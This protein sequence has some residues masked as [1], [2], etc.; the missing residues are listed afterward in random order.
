ME[1]LAGDLRQRRSWTSH[2]PEHWQQIIRR[3]TPT[4]PRVRSGELIGAYESPT[5]RREE[6]APPP[7]RSGR[8][9][10]AYIEA[11]EYLGPQLLCHR[12]ESL[13][14][15][16]SRS[17]RM[18]PLVSPTSRSDRASRGHPRR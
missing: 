8:D 15:A 4:T 9:R 2:S 17:R 12:C 14:C 5:R 16:P 3:P 13:D 10:W 11:K 6:G 18:R 7:R 1:V